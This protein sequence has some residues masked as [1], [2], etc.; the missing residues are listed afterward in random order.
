MKTVLHV[1]DSLDLGGAQ[2]VVLNLAT[3]GSGEFHHEVAALH[4]RGIYR[5]RLR[6]AGVQVHSLAPHKF[7]PLYLATLPALLATLRPRV[8]HAH[9]IPSNILAKPLAATLGAPA[10]VSHDHTNDS[11]RLDSKPLL[12]LDRWANRFAGHFIAVSASCR[13]FLVR[14]ENIDPARISVVRNAI[15]LRRFD[16][17]LIERHSA[18]EK[19]GLPLKGRWVAGV[20][21][22]NPQKNFSLFLDVAARLARRFSDVQFLLA[23][24]GPEESAL[25]SKTRA[26]GLEDRVV[27]SG[28]VADPRLV[29]CAADVLLMPSLFEGLPMT[30]L[31]AMAM[32]LPVVASRLD[33]MAEVLRNGENGLLVPS[34]DAN[35][36]ECAVTRIL[37]DDI[38][39]SAIKRSARSTIETGY[40]VEGMTRAVETVYHRLL[41]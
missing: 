1:I 31:E 2:E 6:E 38:F 33:G 29:Y 32:D 36:F 4:G 37:E 11:R 15:D 20:G 13:D 41:P 23:G 22:L 14:H 5:Q 10:V 39:A 17:R 26:L 21:R 7:F 34:G 16:P 28:Y 35:G 9:L 18:R 12:A 25:K 24:N 3:C 8:V 27:F 19:L 30:L 40:S